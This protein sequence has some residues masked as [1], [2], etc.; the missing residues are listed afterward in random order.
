[1]PDLRMDKKFG[2]MGRERKESAVADDRNLADRPVVIPDEPDMGGKGLKPVPTG[3]FRGH[4][5]ETVQRVVVLQI[6]VDAIGKFLEVSFRQC[7]RIV[8]SYDGDALGFAYFDAH[9]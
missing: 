3:K 1:M 8:R 7:P 6:S 4:D 5:Y 2:K 9:A